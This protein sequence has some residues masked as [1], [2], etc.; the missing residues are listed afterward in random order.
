VATDNIIVLGDFNTSLAVQETTPG[1]EMGIIR[2][3]QS[4]SQADDLFE[5][6]T[7]LGADRPTHASG[8]QFDRVLISPTLQD[9]TG[10]RFITA[11]THRSLSIR[12]T[13][14][15]TSGVDY[16]LPWTMHSRRRNRI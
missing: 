3:F 12:G 5:V 1:S 11:S 16:A 14:D 8:R 2:G 13:L 10:L 15:N 7:T 9:E 6:H 4:A